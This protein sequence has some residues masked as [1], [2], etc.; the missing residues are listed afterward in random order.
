MRE[1]API[2]RRDVVVNHQSSYAEL[3]IRSFGKGTF[4]KPTLSGIELGSKRV[5]SIEPGDLL[6]SNVFA[7][8]GAIAVAKPEDTGR[9]VP[10]V[11][12]RASHTMGS[13]RLSIFVTIF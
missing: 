10:I 3:G 2:V 13:L 8:E 5:Y 1:V 7:W 9:E 4:H 11:S 12:F 6:F